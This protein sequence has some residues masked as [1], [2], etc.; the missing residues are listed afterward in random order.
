[1]R[2]SASIVTLLVA[3][4]GMLLVISYTASDAYL[5]FRDP[6]TDLNTSL[7]LGTLAPD[8]WT[9]SPQ[10]RANFNEQFLTPC[11]A[12]PMLEGTSIAGRG[13]MSFRP[14][15]SEAGIEL[16]M[17][18]TTGEDAR[19]VMDSARRDT[20][21]NCQRGL[22]VGTVT[23][24][25]VSTPSSI[26][27]DEAY[28]VDLSRQAGNETV[29]F[30]EA[31]IRNG[32]YI[33][34]LSYRHEPGVKLDQADVASLAA[35]L[36]E[37]TNTPPTEA[38]LRAAGVNVDGTLVDRTAERLQAEST[39]ALSFDDRAS[40]IVGMAIVGGV[41]LVLYLIGMKLSKTR[42]AAPEPVTVSGP[43]LAW[44]TPAKEST[45]TQN[46]QRWIQRSAH[47]STDQLDDDPAD[48]EGLELEPASTGEAQPSPTRDFPQRSIEE[49]LKI[50]KEARL[51]EPRSEPITPL[52]IVPSVD[53]TE[54]ISRHERRQATSPRMTEST[55]AP[56]RQ[57]LLKKLRP[58]APNTAPP[59]AS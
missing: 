6:E 19:A 2:G 10:S 15:G 50:L 31:V 42:E 59:A 45:P 14:R 17:I 7:L 53:W 33:A 28:V 54:E 44:S 43:V 23:G 47:R 22:T 20:E 52:P 18:E 41:V 1:M 29:D 46:R 58:G 57:I 36:V 11:L 32:D 9:A 3:I 39:R 16:L 25:D 56:N 24:A 21:A 13:A 35:G 51:H 12:V 38:E 48:D 8:G 49:K 4:C 37:R 26:D 40:P 30:T 27:A 5:K 34:R 55:D